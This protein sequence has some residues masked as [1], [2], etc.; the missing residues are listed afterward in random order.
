MLL[1]KDLLIGVTEFMRDAEAFETIR[2][3]IIP[4]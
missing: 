1:E 2:T 3:K 4:K